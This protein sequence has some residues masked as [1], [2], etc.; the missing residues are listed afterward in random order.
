M[1]K[2]KKPKKE[3]DSYRVTFVSWEDRNSRN[4]EAEKPRYVNNSMLGD[5]NVPKHLR[6][7]IRSASNL[8]TEEAENHGIFIESVTQ[9]GQRRAHNI[10]ENN[11]DIYLR[12]KSITLEQHGAAMHIYHDFVVSRIVPGSRSCLNITIGGKSAN[13]TGMNYHAFE[14]YTNALNA[15]NGKRA[16]KLVIAVCC[17]GEWLKDVNNIAIKAHNR[18]DVLQR[19]LDELLRH[20]K[21][22]SNPRKVIVDEA[23]GEQR[24]LENV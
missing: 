12:R 17:F 14:S 9:Q 8:P 1:A 21:S 10:T 20:Y 11:L 22:R 19:A 7:H 5:K 24:I 13:S 23:T 15:I 3:K 2:D 6:D 16:Q 4:K 18:M